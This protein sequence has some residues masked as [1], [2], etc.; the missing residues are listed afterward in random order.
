MD[1]RSR[2]LL[3]RIGIGL[4]AIVCIIFGIMFLVRMLRAEQSIHYWEQ[5]IGIPTP[6]QSYYSS[7]YLEQYVRSKI[8]VIICGCIFGLVII[9]DFILRKSVDDYADDDDDDFAMAMG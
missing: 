5:V 4:T 3:I 6:T 2:N 8:V 9:G 7:L 1:S